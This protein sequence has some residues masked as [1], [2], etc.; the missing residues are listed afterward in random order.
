MQVVCR[1]FIFF[2][3][4]VWKSLHENLF[5]SSSP[6]FQFPGKEPLAGSN[7]GARSVSVALSPCVN[8]LPSKSAA[9]LSIYC[10]RRWVLPFYPLF[11]GTKSCLHCVAS[12]ALRTLSGGVGGQAWDWAWEIRGGGERNVWWKELVVLWWKRA[13]WLRD[14]EGTCGFGE[15]VLN[16]RERHLQVRVFDHLKD[17]HYLGSL[18]L[19]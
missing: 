7:V 18:L 2:P 11:M 13:R 12:D 15:R 17:I 16:E 4:V 19:V 6:L 8:A 14:V 10:V 5:C 1:V 9:S 3:E